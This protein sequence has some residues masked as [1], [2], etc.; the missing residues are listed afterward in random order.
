MLTPSTA[1][2]G[3]WRVWF[4]GIDGGGVPEMFVARVGEEGD[5]ERIG[6]EVGS[7]CP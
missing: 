4:M 6:N 1:P 5:E 3:D 2:F 7:C